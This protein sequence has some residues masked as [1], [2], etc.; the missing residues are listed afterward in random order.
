MSLHSF[1]SEP[2][3]APQASQAKNEDSGRDDEPH[4][5]EPAESSD[6]VTVHDVTLIAL[7]RFARQGFAET[8]LDA[9]AKESG[10][11]KRMIHYHFGDKKGLYHQALVQAINLLQPS[12]EVLNRSYAVPVEGMRKFVDAMFYRMVDQADA[13][14]LIIRENTMPVL[15]VGKLSAIAD[16][17]EVRLHLERLLMMGQDAGAFR[18]C[19]SA[20]D[21]LALITALA[22]YRITNRDLS[23][24]LLNVDLV[25]RENTE[26]MRRFIIDAVLAF[27]TSNIPDSGYASYLSQQPAAPSLDLETSE[28]YE[29]GDGIY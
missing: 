7:Q 2:S 26:G 29:L 22:S 17:S 18:P 5:G 8:K 25:S 20:D 10:M 28:V 14:Q 23:L 24:N 13:L 11:S 27:L 15:E 9:I 3:A 16:I 1:G 4:I 21:I 12:T 19:I 6:N